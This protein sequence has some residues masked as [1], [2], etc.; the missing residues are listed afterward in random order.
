MQAIVVIGGM[1]SSEAESGG[2]G[3]G[4]MDGGMERRKCNNVLCLSSFVQV[5][6]QKWPENTVL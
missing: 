3:E 1:K 4:G 6:L 5:N 2:W